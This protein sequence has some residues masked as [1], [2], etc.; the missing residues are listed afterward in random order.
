[1]ITTLIVSFAALVQAA[2][3]PPKAIEREGWFSSD[4]VP[5]DVTRARKGGTVGYELQVTEAGKLAGCKVTQSSGLPSLDAVVCP[6]LTARAS[7]QPARD[8]DGKAIA[9]IY[10]SK[11][12]FEPPVDLGVSKG[13]TLIVTR[14]TLGLDGS[15][16]DCARE[17]DLSEPLRPRECQDIM[18]SPKG[19]FFKELAPKYRVFRLVTTFTPPTSGRP[20]AS[21]AWG[22][23]LAYRRSEHIIHFALPQTACHVAKVDGRADLLGDGCGGNPKASHG[24]L[25][26]KQSGNV[27]RTE[28]AIFAV[29]R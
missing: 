14:L 21:R 27:A 19:D 29:K 6:I 7:F 23:R 22:D 4:D 9:S 18:R 24:D 12:T 17:G 16:L 11:A 2:G 25:R 8:G 3:T 26:W 1:M 13:P 10:R 20:S 5:L 15:L 28:A